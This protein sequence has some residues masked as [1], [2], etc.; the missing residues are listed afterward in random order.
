VA[1]IGAAAVVRLPQPADLTQ[2]IAVTR[3]LVLE[4]VQDPGNLVSALQTTA[5]S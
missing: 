2:R 3:L 5:V 1:G 4:G